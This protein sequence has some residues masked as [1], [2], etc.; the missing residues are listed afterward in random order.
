[1]NFATDPC[2][3][4]GNPLYSPPIPSRRPDMFREEKEALD[5]LKSKLEE[6]R[7]YL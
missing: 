7:G 1:M 4:R 3:I 5:Q 6:L 2:R